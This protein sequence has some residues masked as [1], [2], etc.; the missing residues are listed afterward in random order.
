MPDVS[1][2]LTGS[3]IG[4]YLAKVLGKFAGT[5]RIR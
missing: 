2:N 3:D 1:G 5:T 4:L